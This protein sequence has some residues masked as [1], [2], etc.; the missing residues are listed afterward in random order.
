M[1][2]WEPVDWNGDDGAHFLQGCVIAAI[3]SA[4]LWLVIAA[5]AGWLS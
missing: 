5:L 1:S 2:D 3:L 4:P